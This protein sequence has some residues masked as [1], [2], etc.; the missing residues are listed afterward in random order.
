MGQTIED[1]FAKRA[2][3]ADADKLL[4]GDGKLDVGVVAALGGIY[5]LD[6]SD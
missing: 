2:A 1:A 3:L 5:I 6:T 4:K